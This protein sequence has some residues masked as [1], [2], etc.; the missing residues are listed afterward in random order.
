MPYFVD[1]VLDQAGN[2]IKLAS[3]TIT[4]QD[5]GAVT[6]YSDALRT[7]V[8]ANPL[9]T[10]A[11]GQFAFYA[12]PGI[13]T[14]TVS[15]SQSVQAS[16]IYEAD[17]PENVKDFGAKGDNLTDDA[18]AF[19]AAHNALPSAGGEIVV[20][21][22]KYLLG[23]TVSF[24]RKTRLVGFGHSEAVGVDAPTTLVKKST[25]SGAGLSVQANGCEFESFLLDGQTGN[26]G[27]G[28]EILANRFVGRNLSIFR[29]GRDGMRIGSDA[30]VNANL[31]ALEHIYTKSNG[32][33]G[34]RVHDNTPDCNGGV[35]VGLDTQSNGGAGLYS[36]KATLNTYVG[37]VAQSNGTYGAYFGSGSNYNTISGGD[38]L[39]S[40]TTAAGN[41]Y[42]DAGS[43]NNRADV[44]IRQADLTNS[45]SGNLV[46]YIDTGTGLF[47][48]RGQ[49]LM[50]MVRAGAN[51]IQATHASGQV[52]LV[53]GGLALSDA[54][55]ALRI[56]PSLGIVMR[57]ETSATPGSNGD[58]VLEATSNTA[59][60][61]KYK[62]SDATVRTVS[63]PL[64]SQTDQSGTFTPKLWATGND[65][66]IALSS[67][68]GV[69]QVTGQ[70]LMVRIYLQ[71][72]GGGPGAGS[73]NL[74]IGGESSA[75]S[76]GSVSGSFPKNGVAYPASNA[77]AY[78]GFSIAPAWQTGINLSAGYTQLNAIINGGTAY[79]L[80]YESG[81]DATS[82]AL[83]AAAL[84]AN[85]QLS[86]TLFYPI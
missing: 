52:N 79:L 42:F 12:R 72:D 65:T 84:A 34:L 41:L 2:A 29:A 31:W 13:Y 76:G 4:R 59:L 36:L 24:T 71:V 14:A 18:A 35:L 11:R 50:Q 61:L 15:S 1:N 60:A 64:I 38:F 23:S 80:L 83:T 7:Q 45:G 78:Q 10:D 43:S 55:S 69:Y 77:T 81:D 58:L 44:V 3:V 28:I 32:R 66:A 57:P 73:G 26:A 5:A 67:A 37:I 86:F 53:A 68:K 39:E 22:G 49:F 25:L 63:L 48:S 56:V 27:D 6:L 85:D 20:P 75:C 21:T 19:Q 82:Q 54:N 33:D 62:G 47:A 51:Y 70:M 17:G 9:T 74:V 40:N 16:R 46:D 30:G 8:L